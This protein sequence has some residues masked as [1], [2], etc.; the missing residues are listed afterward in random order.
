MANGG[1][2]YS[3]NTESAIAIN[4]IIMEGSYAYFF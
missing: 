1:N 2:N 4:V 3:S